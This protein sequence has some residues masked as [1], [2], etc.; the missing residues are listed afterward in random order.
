MAKFQDY[1]RSFG[2][3]GLL[4]AEEIKS[5]EQR[6]GLDLGHGAP[7][8]SPVDYYPQFEQSVRNEASE[9]ARACFKNRF[10]LTA[11][12][13]AWGRLAGELLP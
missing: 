5:V 12:T 4:I 13:Y 9:M 11:G 10:G 8:S 7:R 3:S 2:M 6:F 1:V